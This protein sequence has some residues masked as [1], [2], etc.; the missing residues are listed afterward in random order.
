MTDF[1]SLENF[2]ELKESNSLFSASEASNRLL[3][4]IDKPFTGQIQQDLRTIEIV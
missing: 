4:L 2:K 3:A 1:S